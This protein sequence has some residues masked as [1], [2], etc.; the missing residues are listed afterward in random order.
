MIT[1]AGEPTA[2]R[3]KR[4]VRYVAFVPAKH[5]WSGPQVLDV[6]DANVPIIASS[7]NQ[8]TSGIKGQDFC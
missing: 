5:Q 6:P 1:C 3:G 7:G 2:L 4:Q 8:A